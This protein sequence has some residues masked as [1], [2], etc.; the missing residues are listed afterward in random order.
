MTHDSVK[1]VGSWTTDT[2][3]ALAA[4]QDAFSRTKLNHL[5]KLFWPGAREGDSGWLADV[6][7]P[8]R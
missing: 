3:E 8:F 6:D 4:T 5:T 7:V 1:D 2:T